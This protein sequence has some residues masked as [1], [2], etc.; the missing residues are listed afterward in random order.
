[1]VEPI[2]NVSIGG[3]EKGCSFGESELII[4]MGDM[5]M[6]TIRRDLTKVRE[7]IYQITLIGD[8]DC[9]IHENSY[10]EIDHEDPNYREYKSQLKRVGLW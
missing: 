3:L 1:M 9:S 4:K 5:E 8:S 6:T 10:E 7:C 2:G